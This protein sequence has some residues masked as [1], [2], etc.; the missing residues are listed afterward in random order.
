MG[1]LLKAS[2]ED[3]RFLTSSWGARNPLMLDVFCRVSILYQKLKEV[4]RYQLYAIN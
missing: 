3:D 2:L 1:E 4:N